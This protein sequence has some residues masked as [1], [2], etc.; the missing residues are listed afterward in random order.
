MFYGEF[1]LQQTVLD[2]MRVF[3]VSVFKKIYIFFVQ[4]VIEN[5]TVHR[6]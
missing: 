3:K 5:I 1:E 2:K 6:K 4:G